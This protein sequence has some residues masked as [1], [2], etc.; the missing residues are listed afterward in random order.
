MTSTKYSAGML[1]CSRMTAN[2]CFFHARSHIQTEIDALEPGSGAYVVYQDYISWYSE[3]GTKMNDLVFT[4]VTRRTDGELQ[5]EYVHNIMR[6][7]HSSATT[8]YVWDYHLRS[9]GQGGS[10]EISGLPGPGI[11]TG[12]G[13]GDFQN[14]DCIFAESWYVVCVHVRNLL[15]CHCFPGTRRSMVLSCAPTCCAPITL[16]TPA[17]GLSACIQRS[18]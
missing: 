17:T 4:I 16:T 12:D 10:G 9:E 11:R 8:R 5:Y 14:Y 13:G 1:F 18:F 2:S 7:E 6:C 3:N 15:A